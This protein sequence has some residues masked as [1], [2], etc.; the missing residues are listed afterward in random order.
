M[1]K[2]KLLIE[3]SLRFVKSLSFRRLAPSDKEL[4]TR[5]YPTFSYGKATYG[6]PKIKRW[7]KRSKLLIGSYC[8][9]SRNVQ[10]FLGGNHRPDWVTTFPFP[11]YYSS[12]KKIT[13]YEVSKGDVIIGNDVWLGDGCTILSGVKIG[14][15]AV[16]GCNAVV[17]KD[18]PAYAIMVGNPAKV[19]RYRFDE[20][21]INA[22]LN[23]AW[24]NWPEDELIKN[25]EKLCSDDIGQ[26]I[27]YAESRNQSQ[28]R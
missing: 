5:K 23:A 21:I 9:I 18:V 2:I 11:H 10:I 7:D 12:E 4:F 24:W 27:A 22:L 1:N 17:A 13:K 3:A 6:I 15:G 20:T 8:S 28:F 14:H 26:F 19:A 25:M 16:I